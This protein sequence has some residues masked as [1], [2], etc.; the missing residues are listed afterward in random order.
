MKMAACMLLCA[1]F[2]G[3]LVAQGK[4]SFIKTS[5]YLGNIHEEDGP[6]H[7]TFQFVN[8][9]KEPVSLSQVKVTCGCTVSEYSKE[10]VMPGDTGTVI[11]SY[12]PKMRPGYF[13]K[14]A[15]VLSDGSP[16]SQVIT[17][18]GQV[19]PRPKGPQDY[20]PFQEGGLRF[21]T[22]HLTFDK[23]LDSERKT[24]K[25]IVYN[26]SAQDI[27]LDLANS[28]VPEHLKVRL[29]KDMLAPGD[30]CTMWTTYDAALRKSWGFLFDPFYLRTNDPERPMKR[31][32]TSA[33]I[34]QD[35]ETQGIHPQLR[36][37]GYQFDLGKAERGG[38]TALPI[39]MRNE[40]KGPLVIRRVYSACSCLEFKYSEDT[41]APGE[42]QDLLLVFNTVGR[43]GKI[44]KEFT[45]ITNS[46]KNAV[47][48]LPVSIEV[49]REGALEEEPK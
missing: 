49:V 14:I 17:I 13:R 46:P 44:E 45:L 4:V 18:T 33:T 12:N 43:I 21:K 47:L 30:T 37:S 6:V 20:Y 8:T 27:E 38:K 2:W 7:T 9:G 42:S 3:G 15:T 11:F 39:Q 36:L 32:G 48:N 5:Y 22:N 34:R 1:S 40:G 29:S 19:L 25:N 10:P 28:E 24:L 35:F 23:M 16:S 41:I 31:I 26:G